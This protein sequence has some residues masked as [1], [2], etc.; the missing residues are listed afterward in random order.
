MIKI[1][2]N[3]QDGSQHVIES[4]EGNT[5]MM[6]AYLE[7]LPGIEGTCGGVAACGTCHVA[8]EE[9]WLRACGEIDEVEE[10]RLQ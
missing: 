5:L 3:Y 8:V 7:G 10:R 9:P 6:A 1:T 2:F 4:D